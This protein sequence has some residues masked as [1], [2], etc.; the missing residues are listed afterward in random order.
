M[1]ASLETAATPQQRPGRTWQA[2]GACL[3]AASPAWPAW[4]GAG[5]DSLVRRGRAMFHWI[6]LDC[7]GLPYWCWGLPC[8]DRPRDCC[9]LPRPCMGGISITRHRSAI[10]TSSPFSAPYVH[11]RELSVNAVDLC[12][13][14]AVLVCTYIPT[15]MSQDPR[16]KQDPENGPQR[17][18]SAAVSQI[19]RRWVRR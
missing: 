8:Q 6:A 12:T 16:C 10:S 3:R 15:D 2:C 17:A 14:Y 11:E 5:W 18:A 1:R 4:H 19:E 13:Q 9:A 7:I